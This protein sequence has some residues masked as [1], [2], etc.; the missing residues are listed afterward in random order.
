MQYAQPG[1]GNLMGP[2]SELPYQGP[3]G[4]GYMYNSRQNMM[5][6]W[7]QYNSHGGY[8]LAQFNPPF[9]VPVGRTMSQQQ[10]PQ[11]QG[12]FLHAGVHQNA[13]TSSPSWPGPQ[14]AA[15]PYTAQYQAQMPARGRPFNTTT[16]APLSQP[17]NTATDTD[18]ILYYCSSRPSTSNSAS[19]ALYSAAQ[20]NVNGTSQY[21]LPYSDTNNR[22]DARWQHQ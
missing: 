4:R 19:N 21:S 10:L 14:N 2:H 17:L 20:A 12:G 8:D 18:D 3:A 1:D 6:L 22:D 16:T 7:D 15:M 11:L 9:T 5:P 13:S